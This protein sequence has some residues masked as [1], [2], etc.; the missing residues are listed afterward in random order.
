[1]LQYDGTRTIREPIRRT[2]REAVADAVASWVSDTRG[3]NLHKTIYTYRMNFTKL[4]YTI[5]T[6]I[7]Q[8]LFKCSDFCHRCRLYY[9]NAFYRLILSFVSVYCSYFAVNPS[10]MHTHPC[11]GPAAAIAP[12]IVYLWQ[13]AHG[14]A[15]GESLQSGATIRDDPSSFFK[16]YTS[17]LWW[18][19]SCVSC[20]DYV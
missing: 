4:L 17:Q 20:T 8:K 2:G 5:G 6:A 9:V 11:F 15:G 10:T 1:M 18:H 13:T 3:S 12:D 16:S 14:Q 7:H 19:Y